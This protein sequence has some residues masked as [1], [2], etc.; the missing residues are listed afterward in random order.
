MPVLEFQVLTIVR[1]STTVFPVTRQE[2]TT[3]S[4]GKFPFLKSITK[5]KK[6]KGNGSV[7]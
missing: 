2:L 5:E 4:I 6:K 3:H 1:K 7:W